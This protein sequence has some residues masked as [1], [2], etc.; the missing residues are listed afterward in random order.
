[1]E[2][3]RKKV[4]LVLLCI[5]IGKSASAQPEKIWID[6]DISMG[7]LGKDVDDGIALVMAL[8][9]EEVS[10]RGISLVF[11]NS[12]D[13]DYSYTVTQGLLR[14]YQRTD[15][16]ISVHRGADSNQKLGQRNPAIE[17]LAQALRKEKL[18]IVALGP[19]TNVATLLVLYP[20]LA[21]Q[22]EKII[23]CAGRTPGQHFRPGNGNVTLCDCNFEKDVEA[24]KVVLSAKVKVILSGYEPASYVY[25]NKEDLQPLKNS[26][27]EKDQWV[28]RQL[29]EWQLLWKIALGSKEGF[30]PFDAITIG[31]LIAPECLQCYQ[32]MPVEIRTLRNDAR[33]FS[34]RRDKPYLLTS[35]NFD[36][37]EKVEYCYQASPMFKRV[38]LD[39][40][41]EDA[42]A[43]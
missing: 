20:E 39:L 29:R 2:S 31:Y 21:L 32:D 18:T 36:S 33:L 15:E 4:I 19:A 38:I 8:R 5:L 27:S 37:S 13:I 40:L 42:L 3:Y 16:P 7:K 22:I 10:I 6:T 14:W 34:H 9:S 24:F 23:L 30:I 12:S 26:S 1:M 11:G 41:S 17:A 28:Y 43:Y 35:Y 25:L